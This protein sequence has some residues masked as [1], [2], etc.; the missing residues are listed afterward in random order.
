MKV[1]GSRDYEI[2]SLGSFILMDHQIIQQPEQFI[3]LRFSDPILSTQ[4]LDGLI[5]LANNADLKFSVS[6]NEIHVYP[7]VRQYGTLDMTI[8]PGIKNVSGYSYPVSQTLSLRFEDIKPAVRLIGEGV[9]IPQSGGLLFPFEAVNLKAVDVKIIKIFEDNIAQ[10]LQVN[11]LGGDNELKRAGRLILKKTVNLVPERPINYGEW[12]AFSLDLGELIKP[13]P[14]AI[15]R[16]ELSFRK[17]QSLFPCPGGTP[18]EEDLTGNDDP[19]DTFTEGDMSYWDATYDYYDYDYEYASYNWNERNDPCTDSYFRYGERKAARNVLASNLGII[20]KQGED[21]SLLFAVTDLRTA[22]PVSNV[23]LNLYNFQNQLL[24]SLTTD[25]EGIAGMTPGS[26]PYLLVAK[27]DDQRGY[28]R[29]DQGS[30]I[31]LSQFDVSGAHTQKGVKGFIFGERGVWRP[32]DTLHIA[33]ILEDKQHSIPDD[34]PV[35]MELSDP[36]G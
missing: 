1:K 35:T 2:P 17:Q 33:F 19:F 6:G 4:S 10:F 21:N 11:G 16:V 12:N 28:L 5:S 34:H 23:R 18:G 36:N 27:K 30:A 32:G 9:I 25:N 31:S 20:A 13:D 22:K 26:Q 29:L 15:Y 8:S 3:L 14:G 7:V 24:G